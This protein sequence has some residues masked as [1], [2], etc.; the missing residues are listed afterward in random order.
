MKITMEV[1]ESELYKYK[2]N[3]A[4]GKGI[5][6]EVK[7]TNIKFFVIEGEIH[8][9]FVRNN[10]HDKWRELDKDTTEILRHNIIVKVVK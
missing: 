6:T 9:I 10:Q 2:T 5:A 7:S 1:T 4:S 3:Y 8:H